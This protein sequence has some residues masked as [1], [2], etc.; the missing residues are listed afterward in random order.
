MCCLKSLF[1]DCSCLWVVAG[2]VMT[3]DFSPHKGGRYFD[4][5]TPITESHGAIYLSVPLVSISPTLI[6]HQQKSIG[7]LPCLDARNPAWMT[8]TL[9]EALT[10]SNGFKGIPLESRCSF[11]FRVQCRTASTAVNEYIWIDHS[12]RWWRPPTFTN[13]TMRRSV[14]VPS[15]L[16]GETLRLIES[17]HMSNW[18]A[19]QMTLH[20]SVTKG[21][22]QIVSLYMEFKSADS[23][24]ALRFGVLILVNAPL[25]ESR[26]VTGVLL[27]EVGENNI[28][29]DAQCR[30]LVPR[31]S[32]AELTLPYANVEAVASSRRIY[33][34]FI[35]EMIIFVGR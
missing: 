31:D 21:E 29:M 3:K 13:F 17:A 5:S 10:V 33:H 12:Q 24:L 15:K 2:A 20:L 14:V 25:E 1:L 7:L 23:L 4:A 16:N 28:D 32:W 30:S 18:D 9:L 19:K 34:H 11:T 35:T 27:S 26:R 8:G 6:T 22:S